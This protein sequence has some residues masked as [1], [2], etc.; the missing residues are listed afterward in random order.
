MTLNIQTRDITDGRDLWIDT[1]D[2]WAKPGPD[3]KKP[4]YKKL[5]GITFTLGMCTIT[6]GMPVLTKENAAEFLRR[7]R[8]MEEIYG[9]LM[10]QGP[11]R[12]LFTEAH[13]ER[14]IGMKTNATRLSRAQFE[15]NMK[16]A[17]SN[18]ERERK[19]AAQYAAKRAA[20]T[21]GATS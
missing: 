21:A 6:A 17:R 1:E 12:V 2:E 10:N 16:I 7:L 14:R 4:T 13:I 5:E 15:K 19:R 9:P 3:G 11:T 8:V 20:E 18:E